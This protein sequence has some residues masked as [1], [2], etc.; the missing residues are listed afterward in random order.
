MDHVVTTRVRYGETDQMGVVY[1][2]NY[3]LYFE[4]GRTE[5]MRSR[6][7]T[8]RDLEARGI[9]LVVTEASVRYRSPA[10][11]DE[12]LSIH[13]RIESVGKAS[14]R[15]AYRITGPDGRLCA[16][17]HTDLASL[18]ARKAPCRLPP[19]ILDLLGKP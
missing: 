6:G 3:L 7:A 9:L 15:F 11:Y 8:Y 4:L 18:D 12:D 16:E 1:H 19:E 10:R 2:P 17:G 14:L 13:T 5:L